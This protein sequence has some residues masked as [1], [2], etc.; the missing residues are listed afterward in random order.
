MGKHIVNSVESA[1]ADSLRGAALLSPLKEFDPHNSVISLRTLSP[2]VHLLSGGGSGHGN[3]AYVGEGILSAAV[4]GSIFASPSSKQIEAALKRLSNPHGTVIIVMNYTGDVLNFGL[5]KSRFESPKS[6][7]RIVIVADDVSIPRSQGALTGRR[8]LAATV[9][10]YK[11]AG[12]LAAQ[13]ANLDEV[14]FMAD[15]VNKASGT[16]GI[17][18]E[19]ANVPG[20]QKA[21]MLGDDEIEIG[22]GESFVSFPLFSIF[23]LIPAQVFTTSL[24]LSRRLS[25]PP[26]RSS[27]S[28]SRNSPR[29]TMKNDPTSISSVGLCSYQSRSITD[30]ARPQMMERTASFCSSTIWVGWAKLR[31][32][33]SSRKLGNGSRRRTFSLSGRSSSPLRSASSRLWFYF[34]LRRFETS[35]RLSDI[36]LISL[37]S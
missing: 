3:G 36:S 30:T 1:V 19:H 2:R 15:A 21:D 27:T 29:P 28:F 22:M 5:A 31:W 13:G 20:Q 18:L 33:S 35:M 23:T 12:A 34:P 4:A 14:E 8:G 24:A 25:R 9:L 26:L 17:G 6:P 11:L 37:S 32:G 10:V 16:I 7:T